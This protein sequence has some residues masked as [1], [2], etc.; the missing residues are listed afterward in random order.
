MSHNEI[1]S[2]E[3]IPVKKLEETSPEQVL[4]AMLTAKTVFSVWK[5]FT[6][7]QRLEYMKQLRLYLVEHS[8]NIVQKVVS[9][10]GKVPVEALITEVFT[11]IELIRYYEK[12]ASSILK[13]K[14]VSTPLFMYGRQSEIHYR[15][16]GV[17]GIISPEIQPFKSAMI[18]I[19]TALI[20]GNTAILCP[21]KPL[22]VLHELFEEIFTAIS[23]PSGVVQ[24]LSGGTRAAELLVKEK[25]AKMYI[26]GDPQS[27]KK[28]YQKSSELMIPVEL[29]LS[30]KDAMIVFAD[31][32]LERATNAAVWGAFNNTGQSHT[33]IDRLYVEYSVYGALITRLKEKTEALRIGQ[34]HEAELGSISTVS[35]LHLLQQQIA[36]AVQKGA[37]ILCGGKQIDENHLYFE[38][39]VLVDVD[40]TMN[41]MKEETNGPVIA[42]MPFSSDEEAI[43]LTNDS[44]YGLGCSIWSRNTKRLEKIVQQIET[45]NICLNDVHTQMNNPYL[46]MSGMKQSGFGTIYGPEGLL[47]YCHPISIMTYKGNKTKDFTWYPYDLNQ[48]E[49]I[50]KLIQ[51]FYGKKKKLPKELKDLNIK[52]LYDQFMK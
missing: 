17:I 30:G 8:E 21:S 27:S 47:A 34:G 4:E 23:L 3:P 6:L 33:T 22:P 29:Q 35:Q 45:R 7:A 36:D 46:P 15:P 32:D 49:T 14:K 28:L 38:P 52:E 10:T 42:I 2:F 39:T 20:A 25:P 9:E 26:S 48:Y 31:A 16:M 40:H 41:I 43:H 13:P 24:I 18:P 19:I 50:K 44:Q 5:S 1:F 12:H 37:T 11:T 51:S